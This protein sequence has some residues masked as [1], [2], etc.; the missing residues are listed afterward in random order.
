M[1]DPE[2]AIAVVVAARDEA[3][4]VGE[5]LGALRSVMPRAAL[6]VADD[7]STDGTAEAAMAAGAQVVSRRKAHGKGGNVTAAWGIAVF[8]GRKRC[9][10]ISSAISS[11]RPGE[12]GR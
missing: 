4:R 3:D 12:A 6:W 8:N 1:S 11:P 2:P 10:P 7:A 5:T 9:R